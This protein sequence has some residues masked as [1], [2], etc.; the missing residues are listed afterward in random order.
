[1]Q[2]RAA[3]LYTRGAL[4]RQLLQGADVK[5]SLQR[6]LPFQGFVK[7]LHIAP[8][9]WRPATE[10]QDGNVEAFRRDAFLSPKPV[11]MP[12][13]HFNAL[14]AIKKWFKLPKEQDQAF[15]LDQLYL[16]Q[17]R[18]AMVPLEL[19]RILTSTNQ[20]DRVSFQR[21]DA[22]LSIFLQWAGSADSQT[23][24][25]LYLAQASLGDLPQR[26]RDDLA[27]PELVTDTGR[28]D[29]YGANLWLGVAP[30]YTP[31]HR[32]PNPNLFVQLAGRKIVRLLPPGAGQ[33]VFSVI[34]TVL[35]RDAS[36]T[37][38]D[39]GMMQGEERKLLEEQIWGDHRAGD[40]S[41]FRGQE[42]VLDSGDGL[43]IPKGWWHSIKGVGTGI[44][45][46]VS[47]SLR[48]T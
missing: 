14:P 45:G 5:Q 47:E 13:G 46:S 32:D 43:F 7:A 25:R 19:S 8:L 28:G 26:L 29:V 9:Q 24:Q 15:E 31:L 34:Q 39:D 6:N 18:C 27:T 42:A 37:F 12:R 20:E 1:M 17:F 35:D 10:L 22:P 23:Q 36:P 38:R 33:E 41:S 2:S 4:S 40:G 3:G 30:T 44:N 16:E 11:L 48:I 21:S